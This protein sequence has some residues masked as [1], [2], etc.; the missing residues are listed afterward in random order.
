MQAMGAMPL[1]AARCFFLMGHQF[2]APRGCEFSIKF[3]NAL[4]AAHV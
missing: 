3:D 1:S 4:M 2:G